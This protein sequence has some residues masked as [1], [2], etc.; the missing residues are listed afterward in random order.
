MEEVLNLLAE[1]MLLLV[2]FAMGALLVFVRKQAAK[3]ENKID[4][5]VV[6][7][8]E[9]NKESINQKIAAVLKKLIKR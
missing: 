1:N 3:S 2:G 5:Q 4:D 8:A 6:E 9:K 7:F